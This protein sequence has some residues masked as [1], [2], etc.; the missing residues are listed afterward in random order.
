MQKRLNKWLIFLSMLGF[1][2]PLWG[3]SSV[4]YI[5]DSSGRL[6]QVVDPSGNAATYNYDAVGNLLSITRSASSSTALAIFGFS[7]AQGSVGQTVAIQG[8]N[9]S[10]TLSANAVKFN[11]T[12]AAITAA[13]ANSLTVT[14]P[15]GATTGLISVTVGTTTANSSSNFTILNSPVITS[16]NPTSTLNTPTISNFQVTGVNL[17]GSTFSFVPAFFPAA[18]TPS[19]VVINSNGTLATMTLT[20]ASSA[21]GSFTVVA[22]SGNGSSSAV[23]TAG[24]TLTVIST[25]PNADG[26]GDGLTNIYEGAIGSNYANFSTPGDSI[27]DGWALFYTSAPPLSGALSLALFRRF[28]PVIPMN[29]GVRPTTPLPPTTS[30]GGMQPA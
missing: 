10:T 23:P 30:V 4:Q 13:T 26:D 28:Q 17:T 7:P 15:S 12:T 21:A 1:V 5:H 24:N 22:T 6:T 14:V 27:P 19:N 16:V 18:V 9:F 25:D 2:S 3:Q 8:Q 20:L 29:G 11:G